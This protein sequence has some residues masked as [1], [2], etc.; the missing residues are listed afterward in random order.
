MNEIISQQQIFSF[1]T[2]EDLN[3]SMNLKNIQQRIQDI[4]VVLSDFKKLRQTDR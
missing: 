3:N 2:A 1:P 4:I